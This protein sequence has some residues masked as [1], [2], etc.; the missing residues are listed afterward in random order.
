MFHIT[1][2]LTS[3]HMLFNYKALGMIENWRTPFKKVSVIF[4]FCFNER[5]K[6]GLEII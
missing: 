3:S 4:R 2:E 5:F 6:C 1:I